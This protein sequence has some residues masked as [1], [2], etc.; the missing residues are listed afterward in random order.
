MVILNEASAP[1]IRMH[2][3]HLTNLAATQLRTTDDLTLNDGFTATEGVYLQGA[4]I[5]G[6]LDFTGATLTAAASR[7]KPRGT[8]ALAADG[9][10]VANDMIC[11]FTVTG[12][13]RLIDAHI[14]GQLNL[15][16]A[17]LTGATPASPSG[18]TSLAA[19]GLTVDH[20]MF[21]G[22]TVTGEVCLIDAHIHGRL[23]FTGATLTNP[24]GTA[25]DLEGASASTLLLLPEKSPDGAVDLTNASVR[26][27]VDD[28]KS[29]PAVFH[30]QGFAYDSF[31]NGRVSVRGRLRWLTRHA[32]GFSPQLYDQL[33]TTYR[34]AGDEQATRKVAVAK[35]W[36]RRRRFSPLSWLWYVT[37][38]YGY[39]TWLA[40]LWLAVLVALST[41][42][43]SRAYP[44][45]MI[46]IRSRPPA[47]H[48]VA[49]AFDLLLPVINLG[50]KN[51]WQP[52]GSALLYWSWA[53]TG[54]GWVL[55]SA[56][57]AGLA[58]VLKRD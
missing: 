9:L 21:C 18:T 13:V 56:V 24:S 4:Q 43:F 30:L 45:H 57:V 28:P 27:F 33:A 52:E 36:R 41:W 17:I 7:A 25:L 32:S 58:G 23:D 53:L 46:A 44:A 22:F 38:G 11:G 15:T 54:A 49:Y 47:F 34:R 40:G 8:I 12:E 55:I 42:V 39:R 26:T 19:D 31:G 2:G 35:Q 3:C 50:Q 37:V 20:N 48:A 6:Q 16:G 14:G 1:S 29:W 5:G 10:I 51:A